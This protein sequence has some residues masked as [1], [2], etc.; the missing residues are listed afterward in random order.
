MLAALGE[1]VSLQEQLLSELAGHHRPV[2]SIHSLGEVLAGEPDSGP[3]PV[4]KL[5]SMN[6]VP[7]VH[8]PWLLR[9]STNACSVVGAKGFRKASDHLCARS[10]FWG[11][12][13][14]VDP[15]W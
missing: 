13:P 4:L 2:V 12:K 6:V 8:A 9:V 11:C 3:L 1:V 10:H 14:R 15:S 5:Y 7:L